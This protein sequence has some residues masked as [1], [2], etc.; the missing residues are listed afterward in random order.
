MAGRPAVYADATV[1][2]GLSRL[3]RLDLLTLFPDSV[4]VTERVWREVTQ[5][6]DKPGASLLLRARDSGLLR[7]VDEGN[8][9]GYPELDPGEATVL[10]AAAAVRGLV[11][12]DERKARAV[13]ASDP[14][15]RSRIPRVMGLVG[16]V[17]LAKS[18]GM[19][20]SVQ[21]LLD[22]VIREGFRISQSLYERALHE[23]G[24]R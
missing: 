6:S 3:G 18:S 7:V 24:E 14:F 5:V 23:A 4:L 2:I 17:L 10:T 12:I 11:L 8:P 19:I 22:N 1:L 21:P 20:T 9:D 13:A 16:L 15:L